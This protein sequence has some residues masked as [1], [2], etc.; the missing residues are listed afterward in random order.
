MLIV[1]EKVVSFTASLATVRL[2]TRFTLFTDNCIR[3]KKYRFWKCALFFFL[4]LQKLELSLLSLSLKFSIVGI[5]EK[6]FKFWFNYFYWEQLIGKKSEGS[7][8]SNDRTV[9]WILSVASGSIWTPHI[10]EREGAAGKFIYLSASAVSSF[11]INIENL[12]QF[13]SSLRQRLR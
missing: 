10:S 3:N 1:C 2:P 4:Y 7:V 13:C 8:R 9:D 6:W 11:G 5:M 12:T